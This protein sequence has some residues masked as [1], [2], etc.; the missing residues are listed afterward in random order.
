MDTNENNFI[1]ETP[2]DSTP[3]ATEAAAVVAVAPVAVETVPQ[4]VLSPKEKKAVSRAWDNLLSALLLVMMIGL[5]GVL[6][7][8]IA[9][10]FQKEIIAL[11]LANCFINAIY[12]LMGLGIFFATRTGSGKNV[13]RVNVF[14]IVLI[15]L[16]LL[17]LYTTYVLVVTETVT[18]GFLYA[19]L[20]W[21]MTNAGISFQ[22]SL[23]LFGY[24]IPYSFISGYERRYDAPAA[25][26]V[27]VAAVETVEEPVVEEAVAE[28]AAE[29]APEESVAEVAEIAA[30]ET[31]VA[32][33]LSEASE[34]V[35]L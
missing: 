12:I 11:P 26:A 27:A 1:P 4:N 29:E 13:Y 33:S 8:L 16:P 2:V 24:A 30:E 7:Y 22:I 6:Y 19:I 21:V 20:E 18:S 28:I 34:T 3:S 15:L 17:A 5:S 14:S 9:E 31:V 32:P 35:T 23:V 10:N 25:D